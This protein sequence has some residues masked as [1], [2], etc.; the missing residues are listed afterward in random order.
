MIIWGSGGD[1]IDLGQVKEQ[2]CSTCEKVRPFKLLLQYRFKHLYY[3]F[4]WVSEKKYLLVCDVCHRGWELKAKEVEA[5]FKKH[6][7]PFM[8]RY[9]WT[10]L[11]G[12][13]GLMLLMV[14]ISAVTGK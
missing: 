6:P 12:F 9:G 11:A 10:F 2:Q 1:S 4:K 5:T 13:F 7:I 8:T 14:L 3:I